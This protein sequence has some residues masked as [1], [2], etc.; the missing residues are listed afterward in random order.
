M[1]K[2]KGERFV[3]YKIVNGQQI[4]VMETYGAW[5]AKETEA[6]SRKAVRKTYEKE[7]SSFTLGTFK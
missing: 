6:E 1:E 4:P 7:L 3:G 2:F 5:V